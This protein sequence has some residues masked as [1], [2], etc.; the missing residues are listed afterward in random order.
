MSNVPHKFRQ[1]CCTTCI[2]RTAFMSARRVSRVMLLQSHPRNRVLGALA[3]CL[4]S[5]GF[6][7]WGNA[8]ALRDVH[9]G[10]NLCRRRVNADGLVKVRLGR[11]AP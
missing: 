1:F 9:C 7:I 2:D 10:E 8:G 6:R 11:P 5:A 3:A 4:A